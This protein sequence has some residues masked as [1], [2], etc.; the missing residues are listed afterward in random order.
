MADA[1][2]AIDVLI[3]PDALML[4]RAVAVNARLRANLPTGFAL[5]ASHTPHVTLLQRYVRTDELDALYAA[6]AELLADARVSEWRL[7]ATGLYRVPV[8]GVAVT[9]IDVARSPDLEHL[10]AELIRIVAPFADE[11]GTSAAF[12]TTP[13]A[14]DILPGTVQYVREFVPKFSGA[15]YRPHLTA[16]IGEDA[17]VRSLVEAP[18]ERFEFSPRG[19]AIYQLGEFGTA[20]KVL[21]RE[22]RC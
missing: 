12:V 1:L 7:E 3:E 19:V 15:R 4:G 17:F 9:C 22:G 16:G 11:R 18:F 10:H 2:T 6:V 5:D 20:R 13:A 8:A 21:W 14:P